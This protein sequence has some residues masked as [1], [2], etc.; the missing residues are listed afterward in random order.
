MVRDANEMHNLLK[1]D[2]VFPT[3]I[4][5]PPPGQTR[6]KIVETAKRLHDLLTRSEAQKLAPWQ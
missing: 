3:P 5:D 1:F 4:A 2:G 6:A